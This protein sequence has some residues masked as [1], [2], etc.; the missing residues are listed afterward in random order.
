MLLFGAL[1]W[2]AEWYE[3]KR[4]KSATAVADQAVA[5]VLHGWH[6]F[7][8][9]APLRRLLDAGNRYSLTAP[10]GASAGDR[11]L[12]PRHDLARRSAP[13]PA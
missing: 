7:V 3:P 2:T 13:S 9:G 12:H 10:L 5:M 6:G 4:G 8:A 11:H 1:N